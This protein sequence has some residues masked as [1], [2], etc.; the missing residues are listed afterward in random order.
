MYVE[1]GD[2]L[3]RLA[4]AVSAERAPTLVPLQNPLIRLLSALTFYALLPVAI[5][6]FAW[7]A[8]VFPAWGSDLFSV[9]VAVI[10]SH[11]MLPFGRFS[12]RSKGLLSLSAALIAGGAMLGFGLPHRPFNLFRANLAGQWLVK[13]DLRKA[14]VSRA[15]LHDATLRDAD[16]SDANLS[17]ANL[18]G[19]QLR[20]AKLRGADLTVADLSGAHLSNAD[21][22]GATLTF[23]NL[24]GADLRYANLSGATL[25]GAKLSGA[26]LSRAR[27]SGVDLSD[28]DLSGVDLR[29]PMLAHLSDADLNDAA[30]AQFDEACGGNSATKLPKLL[31]DLTLKP[32]STD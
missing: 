14:N 7:K 4:R 10:A 24:S 15:N 8:A 13:E 19:A 25:S 28:T 32:C 6:L 3:D 1:H 18:S 9:A 22:S 20:F 21:L 26:H 30:R 2:R 31:E 12:W 29:D 16:L 23:A 27:L 5:L 17:G 11:V